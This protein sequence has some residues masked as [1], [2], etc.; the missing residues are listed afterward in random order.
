MLPFLTLPV[1]S[2]KNILLL[3]EDDEKHRVIV[4]ALSANLT[5]AGWWETSKSRMS[6]RLRQVELLFRDGLQSAYPA[7]PGVCC[8]CRSHPALDA[9]D[10][11]IKSVDPDD[12]RMRGAVSC[13]VCLWVSRC[14]VS[15]DIAS[16]RLQR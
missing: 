8:S 12:R 3:V 5:R 1:F 15:Q 4:A 7:D 2:P 14:R 13:H 10:A 11:F 16:N 6:K 9:I